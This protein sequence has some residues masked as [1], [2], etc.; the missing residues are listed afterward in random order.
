MDIV[1][2]DVDVDRWGFQPPGLCCHVGCFW[3]FTACV[4]GSVR[5]CLISTKW[6]PSM[7][8]QVLF[9]F[10][11]Q[12]GVAS[13][14]W[15]ETCSLPPVQGGILVE[16]LL[17]FHKCFPRL[18]WC[19]GTLFCFT[20]VCCIASWQ[21]NLQTS[22][23]NAPFAAGILSHRVVLYTIVR[24]SGNPDTI[25]TILV[26]QLAMQSDCNLALNDDFLWESLSKKAALSHAAS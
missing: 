17:G 23:S 16:S 20:H 14:S 19:D 15:L 10:V 9:S 5:Y 1:D 22:H 21:G 6:A 7:V 18:S 4:A 3:V 2:V 25:I 26:P 11:N 8:I 13:L 12:Q 24:D